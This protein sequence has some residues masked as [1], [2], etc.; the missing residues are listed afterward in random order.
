MTALSNLD[1][2]EKARI[3]NFEMSKNNLIRF[4]GMGLFV[5]QT[6]EVLVKLPF[7]G[8]LVILTEYGKYTLRKSTAQS[9]QTIK[10]KPELAGK[11]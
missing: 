4:M 9:I 6:I 2:G 8:N 5:N 7:G 10:I 11:I 3:A 1:I